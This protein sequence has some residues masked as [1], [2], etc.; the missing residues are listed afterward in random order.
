MSATIRTL[1]LASIAFDP[2]PRDPG[3]RSVAHT[4]GSGTM[5]VGSR[6][7]SAATSGNAAL[8]NAATG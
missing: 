3:A 7:R 1:I 8:G 5:M 2:E 4:T 6:G